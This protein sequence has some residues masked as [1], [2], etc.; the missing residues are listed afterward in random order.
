MMPFGISWITP[1][2]LSTLVSGARLLPQGGVTLDTVTL[3]LLAS[4]PPES[5]TGAYCL[6][7]PH[8]THQCW[9]LLLA[10]HSVPSLQAS[11]Y[12]YA[13]L[14]ECL[15]CPAIPSHGRSN[16]QNAWFSFNKDVSMSTVPSASCHLNT[17]VQLLEPNW[18]FNS[19]VLNEHRTIRSLHFSS[20][21]DPPNIQ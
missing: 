11:M 9:L 13:R 18:L 10:G 17:M 14:N 5:P 1:L 2:L 19:V 16:A 3:G 20:R 12:S 21:L 4:F 15:F 7:S 6:Q 8:P